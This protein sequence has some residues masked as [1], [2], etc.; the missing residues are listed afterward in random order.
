M[1]TGPG[2]E[3][4]MG[5]TVHDIASPTRTRVVNPVIWPAQDR[6]ELDVGVPMTVKANGLP[7]ITVFPVDNV[8]VIK[9]VVTTTLVA[10][11]VNVKDVPPPTAVSDGVPVA[12]AAVYV[13]TVKSDVRP[14]AGPSASNTDTVH[15]IASLKRT[16]VVEPEV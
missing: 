15:E 1:S 5:V 12:P 10:V 8:S 6:S 3:T 9:R 11:S 13:G 7:T 2:P 4:V 16:K 14:T